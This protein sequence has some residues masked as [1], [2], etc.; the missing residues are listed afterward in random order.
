MHLFWKN[1]YVLT[2]FCQVYPSPYL[3]TLTF[4][5]INNAPPPFFWARYG[6]LHTFPSPTA[7]PT[8]ANRKVSL[9]SQFSL[10]SSPASGR[11]IAFPSLLPSLLPPPPFPVLFCNRKYIWYHF[12]SFIFLIA[13]LCIRTGVLKG[14]VR[15]PII[16]SGDVLPIINH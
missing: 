3:V 7:Y 11:K 9:L 8:V 1:N 2:Y 10:S 16:G 6:N 4:L 12:L 13:H 5:K 15:G 14:C